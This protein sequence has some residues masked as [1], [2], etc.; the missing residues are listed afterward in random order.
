[1]KKLTLRASKQSSINLQTI[2][3]LV[4]RRAAASVCVVL[5][6][7][8]L[9]LWIVSLVSKAKAQDVLTVPVPTATPPPAKSIVR[10]RAVYDET[11]RAVRRTS[12]MLLNVSEG[13]SGG[14]GEYTTLTNANGEFEFRDVGKGKYVAMVNAPG[15]ITPLGLLDITSTRERPDFTPILKMFEE[16]NI[17]GAAGTTGIT[18][19]AKRGGAVSGRVTYADGDIAI[20]VPIAV[21]RKSSAAG[22]SFSRVIPNYSTIFGGNLRTDERGMYRISGLPPGEYTISVSETLSHGNDASRMGMESTMLGGNSLAVT[23]YGGTS[24][25]QE[26][27]FVPV[28]AGQE[29][30]DI[31]VTIIER[32]IYTLGGVVQSKRNS[33]PLR[34]ARISLNQKNNADELSLSMQREML[35]TQTDEAGRWTITEI[36]DGVYML[37]VNP[38][39]EY[40][41]EAMSNMNYNSANMN[42]NIVSANTAVVTNNNG[43][44]TRPKYAPREMEVTVAGGDVTNIV[45]EMSEGGRISGKVSLTGNRRLSGGDGVRDGSDDDAQETPDNYIYVRLERAEDAGSTLGATRYD[46]TTSAFVNNSTGEFSIESVPPG[47]YFIYVQ[48]GGRTNKY[49]VKQ[50]T[51]GGVDLSRQ[52]LTLGEGAKV[53][54]VLITVGDDAGTLAGRVTASGGDAPMQSA[55]IVFVPAEELKWTRASLRLYATTDR[56]GKYTV[57]GAPGDYIAIV[58]RGGD[59]AS[60]IDPNFIRARAQTATPVTIRA[61]TTTQQDIKQ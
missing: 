8:A 51:A 31:N 28:E 33:S 11:G 23:Y 54:N 46:S 36:P 22:N 3:R 25:S 5:L 4:E 37:T 52:P 47:R 49:Y 60:R 9:C 57:Q 16:I 41:S 56:E 30:P 45:T 18:V 55:N 48:S 43:A 2:L 6:G 24:Q 20:G 39:Y 13:G 44:S 61:Q 50:I 26:A 29:M 27:K 32:A 58:M 10:G 40:N 53:T 14:R 7:V 42:G 19:R 1:M 21:L 34:G 17:D 38:P 59:D 15:M 35:Q 12:I